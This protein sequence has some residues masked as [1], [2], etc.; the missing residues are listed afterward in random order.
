MYFINFTDEWTYLNHFREKLLMVYVVCF[1]ENIYDIVEGL[2]DLNLLMTGCRSIA[3]YLKI[4]ASNE[5]VLQPFVNTIIE[6]LS[7][8]KIHSV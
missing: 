1:V 2:I 4:I 7:Y 6:I 5:F 8:P 3:N